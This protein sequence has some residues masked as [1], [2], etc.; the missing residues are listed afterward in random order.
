M[1]KTKKIYSSYY[2]WL[3][4][5]KPTLYCLRQ[6]RQ[7]QLPQAICAFLFLLAMLPLYSQTQMK[8]AVLEVM[9]SKY[10]FYDTKHVF[11]CHYS[12]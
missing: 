12:M 5:S 8:P 2:S 6:L 4:V 1:E 7:A 10:V 11:W 9:T 3:S